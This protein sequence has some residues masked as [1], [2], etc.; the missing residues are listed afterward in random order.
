MNST[1]DQD[2]KCNCHWLRREERTRRIKSVQL[3][4]TA[5]SLGSGRLKIAIGRPGYSP[6]LIRRLHYNCSHTLISQLTLLAH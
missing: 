6:N 3:M 1:L 4:E 2:G 5:D